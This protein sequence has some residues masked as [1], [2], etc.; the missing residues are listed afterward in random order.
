MVHSSNE[1]IKYNSSI[2]NDVDLYLY[3]KLFTF[4][5]GKK[6]RLQNSLYII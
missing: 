5:S 3:G 4:L 6:S 1:Y 2:I